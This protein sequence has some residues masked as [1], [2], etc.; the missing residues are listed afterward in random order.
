VLLVVAGLLSGL[1]GYYLSGPTDVAFVVSAKTRSLTME[2]SCPDQLID[3]T[4]PA[5]PGGGTRFRTNTMAGYLALGAEAV[6]GRI[7]IRPGT[8][9]EF[10]LGQG[11]ALHIALRASGPT[12]GAIA[13]LFPAEGDSKGV[14]GELYIIVP[15]GREPLALPVRG[16]IRLGGVLSDGLD[17]SAILEQASILARGQPLGGTETRTFLSEDVG[18]GSLLYSHPELVPPPGSAAQAAKGGWAQWCRTAPGKPPDYAVGLLQFEADA[19]LQVAFIRNGPAVGLRTL[20]AA[21]PD[22]GDV[23]RLSVT[24]WALLTSSAWAQ[25]SVLLLTAL[26]A[27]LSYLYQAGNKRIRLH[28]GEPGK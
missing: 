12:E 5:G 13:E 17:G 15:A 21:V 6:P 28:S 4:L 2:W 20:G 19:P 14:T 16:N 7:Q 27:G 9:A 18:P 24:R 8:L 23:V 3:W 10:R 26:L 11:G 1:A 25:T 22:D